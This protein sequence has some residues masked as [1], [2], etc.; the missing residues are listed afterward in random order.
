MIKIFEKYLSKYNLFIN[1]V[2]NIF[3]NF[4]IMNINK[5]RSYY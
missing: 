4:I 3:K 5:Q 1:S 2:L